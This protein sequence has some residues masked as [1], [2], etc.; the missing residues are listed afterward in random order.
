M[1]ILETQ[2]LTRCF[3][4]L[5]AVDTLTI[6]VEAGEVFGL[7]GLDASGWHKCLRAGHGF[8]CL[9]GSHSHFGDH[10]W[11]AVSKCS[12]VKCIINCILTGSS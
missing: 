4:P 12:D 1:P 2:A 7:L 5:T 6:S 3:G 9:A 11:T 8:G 10:R